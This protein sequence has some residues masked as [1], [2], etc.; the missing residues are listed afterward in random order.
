[1]FENTI[2]LLEQSCKT[3]SPRKRLAIVHFNWTGDILLHFDAVV[4][5]N[6][7]KSALQNPNL[8]PLVAPY[9]WF[10]LPGATMQGEKLSEDTTKG[11]K[12][13]VDKKIFIAN[14]NFFTNNEIDSVYRKI[15]EKVPYDFN[16]LW[17]RRIREFSN[18]ALRKGVSLTPYYASKQTG[19]KSKV[20]YPYKKG[21]QAVLGLLYQ[22]MPTLDLETLDLSELCDLID[23]LK[24]EETLRRR[25]RLFNW[26]NQIQAEVDKGEINIK[27]I[28][29]MIA[30]MLDDYTEWLKIS[31]LK[32]NY[33]IYES[34]LSI[35]E[36]IVTALSIVGL[37]KAIKNMMQFRKYELELRQAELQAPGRELAF[38]AHAKRKFCKT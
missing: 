15:P 34:L 13:L 37:P 6:V 35:P 5:A 24:D 38:I 1:M 31:K 4:I 26:Q 29:D 28:P 9:L 25:R 17:D 21:K 32:L 11:L 27:H 16:K 20:R 30:T 33:G 19:K 12:R 22:E 3:E 36:N 18:T 2:N 10:I 8:V 7:T 23:F 14:G